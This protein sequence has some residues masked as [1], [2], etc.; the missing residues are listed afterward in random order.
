MLQRRTEGNYGIPLASMGGPLLLV[1]LL[2][3]RRPDARLL[4]VLACVPQSF[5]FYDQLPLWLIPRTRLQSAT[6]SLLSLVGLLLAN[7]SLPANATTA[8]VSQNYW[9]M[10]LATCYL[11]ALAMIMREPNVGL[12]PAWVDRSARSIGSRI[13]KP[14]KALT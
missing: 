9:P 1:A 6:L 12:V 11:P 4:L 2:R 7:Q 13:G 3:W 5:L 8:Q 14:A 10:I